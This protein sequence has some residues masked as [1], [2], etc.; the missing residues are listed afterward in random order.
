[1]KRVLSIMLIILLTFLMILQAGGLVG[2]KADAVW[3]KIGTGFYD[4]YGMMHVNG[5]VY[6][7]NIV[8]DPLNSDHLI[9]TAFMGSSRQS[10]DGGKTWEE[11]KVDDSFKS[12]DNTKNMLT[13][14]IYLIEDW[15]YFNSWGS[16]YK[17]QDFK[18]YIQIVDF[19][20]TCIDDFWTDG[21]VFYAGMRPGI[22]SNANCFF[23]SLDSGKTWENLSNGIKFALKDYPGY[24]G[25]TE[26][27]VYK[28][29]LF[30]GDEVS[31]WLRSINK[32]DS[33]E[34]IME[35]D[36][37]KTGYPILPLVIVNGYLWSFTR[38]DS[39]K[40][41][42]MRSEDGVNWELLFKDSHFLL[43]SFRV[44][45]RGVIYAISYI[46]NTVSICYSVD[47]GRSWILYNKGLSD[48]DFDLKLYSALMIRPAED[49]LYLITK[50]G[51]YV[52]SLPPLSIVINLQIGNPYMTVNS[53]SQE[54]DPGRE[55]KPVIENSRTLVPIRAIVESLGGSIE[56]EEK[57]RK[58]TIMFAN[59]T[60]ELWIGKSMAK[61]DDIDTPIDP[62]NTKVVP[63]IINSRTMLPLRFV[64]ENLGCDVQWDGTTKTVTITY[65]P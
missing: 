4:V 29:K 54:I 8:V 27:V 21:V 50:E 60:V 24:L 44:D 49:K 39:G 41:N 62:V 37:D 5:T 10:F 65:M 23:R 17:T 51:V 12:Y 36:T 55:T 56:W 9:M 46:K 22:G 6:N 59:K 1:M 47:G 3:Q 15:W 58:V 57:E 45:N 26:I 14:R 30:V 42:I 32:G 53:V 11:I 25:V 19:K 48:S 13:T 20:D 52:N 28:D 2:I 43:G 40:I 64:T 18:K 35:E 7:N 34:K 33:F 63:V 31:W 16:I 38:V 61:V